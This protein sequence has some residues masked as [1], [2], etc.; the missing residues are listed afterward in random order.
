[1]ADDDDSNKPIKNKRPKPRANSEPNSIG[2]GNK[3]KGSRAK[4]RANSEPNNLGGGNKNKGSRAKPRANSKPNSLANTEDNAALKA[5]INDIK[6]GK[7][8][9]REMEEGSSGSEII[10]RIVSSIRGHSINVGVS[11][12][13]ERDIASNLSK[14]ETTIQNLQ[15]QLADRGI[16]A[17]KRKSLNQ[18]LV[19]AKNKKERLG[20]ALAAERMSRDV[21]A[22]RRLAASVGSILN[23]QDVGVA[24][25]VGSEKTS[26]YIGA[27]GEYT[28]LSSSQIRSEIEKS[29]STVSKLSARANDIAQSLRIDPEN[30]NARKAELFETAKKIDEEKEKQSVHYRSLKE[31]KRVGIDLESKL[32]YE[33]KMSRDIYG[34]RRYESIKDQIKNDK[35]LVE[36]SKNEIKR[37]DKEYTETKDSL[38]AL[39]ES[40]KL[41]SDMLE[42]MTSQLKDLG[43]QI[44]KH[45]EIIEIGNEQS[46][47]RGGQIT[48]YASAASSIA[49]SAEYAVVG[50]EIRQ[51]QART[52]LME[53]NN[54]RF[55]LAVGAAGGDVMSALLSLDKEASM[56]K[57]SKIGTRAKIAGAVQAS[58]LVTA[59]GG[60]FLAREIGNGINY[61]DA[62][63]KKTLELSK[64]ITSA[65]AVSQYE[66]ASEQERMA[67]YHI[68]A[69]LG[70]RRLDFNLGASNAV[71]GFGSE[72]GRAFNTID[73]LDNARKLA[74][75]GMSTE[76]Q[77]KMYAAGG[78]NMGAS[79]IN[80]KD[81]GYGI[82]SR[83]AELNENRIISN[84]DYMSS[85]STLNAA[86]AGA[87]SDK[88]FEEVLAN[89][90]ERGVNNAKVLLDMSR[91]IGEMSS[92]LAAKGVDVTAGTVAM[93][94]SSLTAQQGNTYLSEEMKQNRSKMAIDRLSQISTSSSVTLPNVMSAQK[95]SKMFPG[96]DPF[97]AAVMSD[98]DIK[99]SGSWLE[100]LRTGTAEDKLGVANEIKRMGMD[101]LLNE[102]GSANS[103]SI[104]KLI[105]AQTSTKISAASGG[106]K[107]YMSEELV[108]RFL[109]GSVKLNDLNKEQRALL[110]SMGLSDAGGSL[111]ENKS[112]KAVLGKP[113]KGLEGSI[114][115]QRAQAQSLVNILTEAKKIWG[116]V[117]AIQK[118]IIA[119]ADQTK[120][121]ATMASQTAAV[122]AEMDISKAF[123]GSVKDFKSAVDAF[124]KSVGYKVGTALNTTNQTNVIEAN[125]DGLGGVKIVG[126]KE[127]SQ[128]GTYIGKTFNNIVTGKKS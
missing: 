61:A 15:H 36:T 87:S 12:A 108:S 103:E 88:R 78:Q 23:A 96:I 115:V 16:S 25:R 6:I 80:R 50:S 107:G 94:T 20:E 89:A 127:I 83:A 114:E 91:G 28:K 7:K 29:Q 5:A 95:V 72:A 46:K 97:R 9:E 113:G 59:S 86:G 93:F 128:F 3:N 116:G 55:D 41:T 11:S 109:R 30:P 125:R 121:A 90:T 31:Q 69:S 17:S 4:S 65:E 76:D 60:S 33:Q 54:R 38:D 43:S 82:V 74:E 40:G 63:V 22:G 124:S 117:D 53:I 44:E 66:N 77:L 105:E 112:G 24:A 10:D 32:E 110:S 119:V 19:N 68:A 52:A 98:I 42:E 104:K 48:N 14:T 118:T 123:E 73:N 79:F 21:E 34:R 81:S 18:S 126:D 67:L 2:G 35:N 8:L 58:A 99:E 101:E 62:A 39:R 45:Q 37:L 1:M 85:L 106:G 84:Q 100:K 75:Y 102:D 47:R 122:G 49:D 56:R 57:S 92:E 64:G 120:N 51:K 26:S 111:G 70:Q 27:L 71:M 13:S